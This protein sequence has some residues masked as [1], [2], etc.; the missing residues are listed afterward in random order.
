MCDSH[1][2]EKELFTILLAARRWGLLWT[3]KRVTVYTDSDS[4]ACALNKGTPPPPSPSFMQHIRELFWISATNNF[5]MTARH[6]KGTENTLADALSRLT[7][8]T[9]ATRAETDLEQWSRQNSDVIQ[10]KCDHPPVSANALSVLPPQA[11]S[12]IARLLWTRTSS[13]SGHNVGAHVEPGS[14]RFIVERSTTKPTDATTLFRDELQRLWWDH[15]GILPSHHRRKIPSFNR[16]QRKVSLLADQEGSSLGQAETNGVHARSPS[17]AASLAKSHTREV[18]SHGVH[19]QSPSLAASLAKSHTREVP[20]HCLNARS[21]SLAAS[22]AK[23]HTREVPSHCLNARS[24]S[25]KGS[26]RYQADTNGVLALNPASAVFLAKSHTREVPSTSTRPTPAVFQREVCA[27][28]L[29]PTRA[30]CQVRLEGTSLAES[31]RKGTLS[32][33]LPR[34]KFNTR[35]ILLPSSTQREV[36][37]KSATLGLFPRPEEP[38]LVK[39]KLQLNSSVVQSKSRYDLALVHL[40]GHRVSDVHGL[41][42]HLASSSYPLEGQR[43]P[44][45][46]HTIV[47]SNNLPP[48][49][50]WEARRLPGPLGEPLIVR[51]P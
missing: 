22:L 49:T 5:L 28:R 27:G 12:W 46:S 7:D 24:P 33:C 6:V 29:R 4:S 14:P 32:R 47:T 42:S 41:C 19:A 36:Y 48:W 11:T 17:L 26:S 44:A 15:V 37:E 50:D 31:A 1:I 38:S 30:Y 35:R 20:S 45:A 34:E 39:D 25:L 9:C 23:S 10:I 21:P 13:A 51:L 3:N 2:N 8:P 40:H 16:A 43:T 18:P